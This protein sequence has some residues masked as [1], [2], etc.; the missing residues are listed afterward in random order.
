MALRKLLFP[1]FLVLQPG[2]CSSG[3]QL[4]RVRAGLGGEEGVGAAPQEEDV[5]GSCARLR[6]AGRTC[7]PLGVCRLRLIS[8]P[9]PPL[10]GKDCSQAIFCAMSQLPA[11]AIRQRAPGLDPN[12]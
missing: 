5:G 1:P 7:L 2:A 12:G 11:A 8:R 6:S 4:E 9:V 3:K 10:M